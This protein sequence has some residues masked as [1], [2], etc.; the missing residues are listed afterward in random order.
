MC[1]LMKD[2]SDGWGGDVSSN[3]RLEEVPTELVQP[4]WIKSCNH[5]LLI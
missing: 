5:Q 3:T 1:K 2:K 4:S